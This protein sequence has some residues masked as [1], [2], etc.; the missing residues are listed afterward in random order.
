MK[1]RELSEEGV[2]K[3]APKEAREGFSK[4]ETLEKSFARYKGV[5]G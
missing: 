4:E 2:I 1:N 5:D 3:S